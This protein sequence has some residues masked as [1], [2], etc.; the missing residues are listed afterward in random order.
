MTKRDLP[1]YV[2][3]HV[4]RYGKLRLYFRPPGRGSTSLPNDPTS[5]EFAAAYRAAIESLDEARQTPK[6]ILARAKP[7]TLRWLCDQYFD[8]IEF[9]RLDPRT[10][11]TRRQI[12]EHCLHEKIAPRAKE[13]FADCPLDVVTAK[14]IKVLRDRKADYPEAANNRIKAFRQIYS[15]ALEAEIDDTIKGN[16]AR[17]VRYFPSTGEGF[18]SW[19]VD[20]LEQFEAHHPIGTRA[21]LAL[22]LLLYTGQRRSDVVRF[23]RQHVRPGSF[24]IGGEG[25]RINW[26]FFTQWKNRNRKPIRLEIPII[27]ELQRIIDASSTGDLTFLVTEY[28]HPFTSNGFGNKMRRWCDEAGLPQCSSHGLRKAAAVRLAELGCTDREIM[29]ILGHIT[30]KQVDLYTRGVRQRRLAENVLRRITRA[31]E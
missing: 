5:P 10:Q 13:T 14:A 6:K 24:E 16:P 30:Q 18:H 8:C 3:R 21:R 26:L 12:I 22:A 1:R 4:D 29:S 9:K 11:R 25:V 17:D 23:G 31:S 19:T 28:G 20:E 15:W 27:P 2:Y 7:R